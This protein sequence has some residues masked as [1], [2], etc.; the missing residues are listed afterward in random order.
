MRG[1]RGSSGLLMVV[2]GCL[3]SHKNMA[4]HGFSIYQALG[5]HM[6]TLVNVT[7]L[8]KTVLWGGKQGVTS[9]KEA[10]VV[11]IV[12]VS[13][14]SLCVFASDLS[15]DL[16]FSK[17][18]FLWFV[19]GFSIMAYHRAGVY[20]YCCIRWFF[21]F[22]GGGGFFDRAV[23]DEFF[24]E[25]YVASVSFWMLRAPEEAM[26]LCRWVLGGIAWVFWFRQHPLPP[27]GPAD[28]LSMT[29]KE[30]TP[31]LL[32]H[33]LIHLAEGFR[34]EGTENTRDTRPPRFGPWSCLPERLYSQGL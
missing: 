26:L 7:L 34:G 8:S 12:F 25:L 24:P 11:V 1:W 20:C 30:L 5:G 19:I 17:I 16:P 3:Q 21:F 28:L 22:W 9:K 2:S 15:G 6:A 29:V 33:T 14:L 10:A 23:L 32:A 18:A 31:S 4:S 13:H 27:P